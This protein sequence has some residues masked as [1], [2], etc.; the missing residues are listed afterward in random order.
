MCWGAICWYCSDTFFLDVSPWHELICWLCSITPRDVLAQK[1]RLPSLNIM[2][3]S[4]SI[5]ESVTQRVIVGYHLHRLAQF[6]NIVAR[7]L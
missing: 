6:A 4:V 7:L 5:W 3:S 1:T 2:S